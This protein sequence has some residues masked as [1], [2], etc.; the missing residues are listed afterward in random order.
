MLGVEVQCVW[1]WRFDFVFGSGMT[2]GFNDVCIICQWNG[3]EG[4]KKAKRRKEL[5][6]ELVGN[7]VNPI[8]LFNSSKIKNTKRDLELR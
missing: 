3:T 4:K 6:K 1:E 7:L 2:K 8:V 5:Q